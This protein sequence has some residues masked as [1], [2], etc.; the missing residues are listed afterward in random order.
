[1]VDKVG[2]CVCVWGG[3]VSKQQLQFLKAYK[4]STQ[5]QVR[6]EATKYLVILGEG[7]PATHSFSTLW[8]GP[9][10]IPYCD[11]SGLLS[12]Q[13]TSQGGKWVLPESSRK[14]MSSHTWSS[15]GFLVHPYILPTSQLAIG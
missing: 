2:V 6:K 7:V 12:A 14:E 1:M 10:L 5:A 9:W 15:R 8:G 4:L 3:V 11:P 13:P